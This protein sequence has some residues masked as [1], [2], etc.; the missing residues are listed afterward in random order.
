MKNVNYVAAI[1]VAACAASIATNPAA[2][3]A[4]KQAK[5][6][7][8]NG[9]SIQAICMKQVGAYYVPGEGGWQFS[10]GLGTAQWQ[11]Y[12]DCVDSHTRGRR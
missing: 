10:G 3:A 2:A 12:Y 6:R 8:S 9:G 4:K 11:A 5:Q 7:T 1:L